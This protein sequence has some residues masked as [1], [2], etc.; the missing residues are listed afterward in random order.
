MW[1]NIYCCLLACTLSCH[2]TPG[3]TREVVTEGTQLTVRC[4]YHLQG[5]VRWSRESGGS[6]ADILTVDGDRNIKHIYDPQKR[7]S[8]WADWS[9]T[10]LRAALSHSGRYFCNSYP[11]EELTVIPSGNIKLHHLPV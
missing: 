2:V 6:R 9:L 1:V 7:Y 3:L 8:S 10:I 11:A 5:K 4:P